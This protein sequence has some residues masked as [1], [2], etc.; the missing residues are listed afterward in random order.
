M[1]AKN[2][3]REPI[4]IYNEPEVAIQFSPE[5]LRKLEGQ[6]PDA[7]L[8]ARF[9]SVPAPPSPYPVDGR[10]RQRPQST[11]QQQQQQQQQSQSRTSSSSSSQQSQKVDALVDSRVNRELGLQQEI[12]LGKEQRSADAVAREAED[13]IRR[14]RIQPRH[15][16]HPGAVAAQ[17]A[18]VECYRKNQSR[19]LDCWREVE[20]M[21]NEAKKAQREFVESH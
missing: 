18:V 1:G 20:N 15:D 5:L 10:S 14:Q 17:E 21:K 9:A 7:A 3:K 8:L 2:S 4:I 13:L 6:P 16:V 12:R 11:Q 19:P